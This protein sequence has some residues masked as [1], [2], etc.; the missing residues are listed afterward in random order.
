MSHFHLPYCSCAALVIFSALGG[1]SRATLISGKVIQ[2]DVSMVGTVDRGDPRL[3]Q[4][5]LEG[6]EV[7]ARGAGGRAD[8][9]LADT[10]SGRSGDFTLRIHDHEAISHP[11]EF[12]GHLAGYADAS[13]EMPLPPGD[14]RLLIVLKPV[15]PRAAPR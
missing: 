13:Q 12:R 10:K 3:K 8:R 11:A 15:G 5:G 4:S 7:S 1:C 14:R 9:I 6:A 2:G